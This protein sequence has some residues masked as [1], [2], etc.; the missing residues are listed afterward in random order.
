MLIIRAKNRAA[1][2]GRATTKK[3]PHVF[4][5]PVYPGL[6]FRASVL[7]FEFVAEKTGRFGRE[8]LILFLVFTDFWYKNRT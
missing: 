1:P 6:P 7:I 3:C 5:C 8:D 4:R 2:I